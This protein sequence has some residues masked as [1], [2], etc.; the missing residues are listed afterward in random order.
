[1][2][3][4]VNH[5]VNVSQAPKDGSMKTNKAMRLLLR[6]LINDHA[7]KINSITQYQPTH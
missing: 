2:H 4:S 7:K 5:I 6:D 1:M 3:T